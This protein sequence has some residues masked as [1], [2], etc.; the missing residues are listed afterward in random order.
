MCIEVL[1]WQEV[2]FGR[3]QVKRGCHAVFLATRFFLADLSRV[4]FIAEEYGNGE[5]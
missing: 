1:I 3:V 2:T 5:S 4:S